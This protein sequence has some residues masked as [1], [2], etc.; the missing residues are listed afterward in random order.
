MQQLRQYPLCAMCLARGVTTAAEVCDH[1]TPHRGDEWLFYNG[2]LQS[3]CGHCHNSRKKQQETHGYQ[4]D[5]GIDGWPLDPRHP[6]N[7]PRP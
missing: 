4:R 2:E 1:V 3:L 7:K 6:A 5:V